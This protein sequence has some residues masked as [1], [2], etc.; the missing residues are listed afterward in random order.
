MAYKSL[1][2]KYRPQTFDEVYGQE[3]IVKT[4]CNAIELDKISHAYLFNGTRGTGKTTIAKIFAKMVNCLNLKNNKPCGECSICKCENTEEIP[5]IIE[6]DAASN[7][8]VDEIR[9]LKNKIKLMPVMCKYKVYIIDEVHMLSTGAF[10]ALL[11]TLEEPPEHVIFIL[12]TTE[13]QKLPITIISRCQ[14]F[15]FKKISINKIIERLEYISKKEKI[16]ISKDALEEIAKI[17]DGALRDAIGMLDQLSSYT[18]TK[19]NVNDIYELKGSIST[20]ELF[21]LTNLYISGNIENLLDQVETIYNNGK[22][23]QLLTED[24][25]ML[26]RNVLVCKKAEK[27]FDNKEISNKEEIKKIAKK[28]DCNSI[29]NIINKLEDL[30]KNIKN[31]NYPRILFEVNML[32]DF[33]NKEKKDVNSIEVAKKEKIIVTKQIEKEEDKPA[34]EIK[35]DSDN[36]VTLELEEDRK[37]DISKKILI[38]NTIAKASTTSKKKANTIYNELD[39]FIIDKKYKNAATILKDSVVAAA[40][41]DHIL[42]NYKYASMVEENDRELTNII[43]LIEKMLG[44]KYKL[45]A[46]TE[47]EWKK[48]R[49]HY[50]ELKRQNKVIELMEEKEEIKKEKSNSNDSNNYVDL[51]GIDLIEME[52]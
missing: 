14:R 24:M 3:Y 17:S 43:S 36:N 31:S 52:E 9:E 32:S 34:L 21:K 35:I 42:L 44:T 28:L 38:N 47:E 16:E 19:I 26:F 1:Y 39:K 48:E 5:D 33:S 40:S 46:I 18:N 13:P 29:E 30:S 50:L 6:I 22:S 12:A 25:L 51:F 41:E 7:N 15:D 20:E 27:Y 37:F 2:R 23:F 4:L 45:V 8:G 11:K 49:P 10:N